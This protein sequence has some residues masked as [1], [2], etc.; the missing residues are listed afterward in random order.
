MFPKV[1][2]LTTLKHP[3]SNLF[4]S[5]FM[6]ARTATDTRAPPIR[7]YPTAGSVADLNILRLFRALFGEGVKGQTGVALFMRQD[8]TAGSRERERLI[9]KIS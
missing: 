9:I 3:E 5:V 4:V 8:R 2:Q 7:C 1:S 6:C